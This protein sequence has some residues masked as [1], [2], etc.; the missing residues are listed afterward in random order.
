[1][2]SFVFSGR[3]QMFLAARLGLGRS[4]DSAIDK[5]WLT[6]NVL[7]CHKLIPTLAKWHSAKRLLQKLVD[8]GLLIHVHSAEVLRDS[9]AYYKLPD[10][11]TPSRE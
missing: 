5:E 10:A 9:R 8:K 1:M 6:I 2:G 4:A 3:A 7:Q 11:F